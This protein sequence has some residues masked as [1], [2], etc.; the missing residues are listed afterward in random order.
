[1]GHGAVA[2]LVLPQKPLPG[3]FFRGGKGVLV[4]WGFLNVGG[5]HGSGY[6]PAQIR[7]ALR[8]PKRNRRIAYAYFILVRAT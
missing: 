5:P 6:R 4:V 7:F 2:L 8:T 1:M 3:V